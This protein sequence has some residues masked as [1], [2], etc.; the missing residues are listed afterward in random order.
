[1]VAG[2]TRIFA[3]D[4]GTKVSGW[5]DLRDGA[6]IDSGVLSNEEL[7]QRLDSVWFDG[8]ELAVERFEARGMPMGDESLETILWTG[9]FIQ[10]WRR[11][12][13]VIRVKRSDVKLALCGTTRAKDANIRQALIDKLGPPGTKKNP[14]PT[15]GVTSHAWAALGVAVTAAGMVSA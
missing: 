6:V 13:E 5:A 10:S 3:I 9:R 12:E 4:P 1:M 2:V 14:G 7:V 11:P 15:Y 8:C